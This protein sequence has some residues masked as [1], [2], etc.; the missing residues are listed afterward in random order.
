MTKTDTRV[1]VA[2]N[3]KAQHDY[4]LG[5]RYEAGLVLTG[6]EIK[7]LR[8]RQVNLR[9]SYVAAI[10][11]ELW[12][13][14]AHISTYDMA[15]DNHDPRRPRKLLLHRKEIAE[16]LSRTTERGY[17]LIPTQIYLVRGRAKIEIAPAR[18]RRQYDKRHVLA[19]KESQRDIER[20][21]KERER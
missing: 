5:Q 9:D 6:S 4:D 1:V 10:G 12:L 19:A 3:R 15:R 20:A 21:L 11:G 13:F 16:L 18:G 2:T 7:S 14:N 17:T 8:E